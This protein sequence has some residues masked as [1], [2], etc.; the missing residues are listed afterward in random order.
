MSNESD[1]ASH[2]KKSGGKRPPYRR[3]FK[4]APRRQVPKAKGVAADEPE[5]LQAEDDFGVPI[6]GLPLPQEKWAHTGIHR[7]PPP[8][9]VDWHAVF[10]RTAPLAVDLGCGNG[11]Y[12]IT[13]AL[14]R[15]DWDHLGIDALPLVIRYATR[16][17]NQR[18]LHNVRMLVCGGHEFLEGYL[19]LESVDELHLY[20]PQ[21]FRT[22]RDAMMDKRLVTPEFLRLAYSRLKPTGKFIVQTDNRAYWSYIRRTAAEFFSIE[23]QDGPWPDDPMGRTRREIYSRKHQMQVWRA[24]CRRRTDRSP[25]E[26]LELARTLPLPRFDAGP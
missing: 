25:E 21:P 4:A 2:P 13:S 3:L 1:D 17:A 23:E 6:P 9:T 15:P 12:V 14:R 8:G 16:R 7:L 20:H 11:R 22:E 10:N 24:T 26:L 18:G 19:A 5:S